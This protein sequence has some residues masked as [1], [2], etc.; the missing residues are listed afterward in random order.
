MK[1]LGGNKPVDFFFGKSRIFM[2]GQD[3]GLVYSN[4][5]NCKYFL[6]KDSYFIKSCFFSI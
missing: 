4:V 3:E 2:W 5:L 1:V 6:F